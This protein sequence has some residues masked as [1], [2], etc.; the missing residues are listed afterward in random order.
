MGERRI[1]ADVVVPH[2]KILDFGLSRVMT[3]HA[4][5]LGGTRRW[6]APELILRKRCLSLPAA[7]VY[8]VGC[9]IYFIAT[10]V[11]PFANL[12]QDEIVAVA[13][14]QSVEPLFWP[15]TEN[16]FQRKCKVRC[17]ACCAFEPNDRPSMSSLSIEMQEAF[18]TAVHGDPFG[19]IGLISVDRGMGFLRPTSNSSTQLLAYF[20]AFDPEMWFIYT[21]DAWKAFSPDS[22]SVSDILEEEDFVEFE[23]F[24]ACC[25]N[26]S[27]N[28]GIVD[29]S[30][31][32]QLS[33]IAVDGTVG[34]LSVEIALS[35]C[36]TLDQC[37]LVCL[38]LNPV[39]LEQGEV[40]TLATD[41]QKH[42][43]GLI[44]SL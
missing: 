40:E 7:D 22:L 23:S 36:G 4:R 2:V 13:A 3:R 26:T 41:V 24:M 20:D 17:Q 9:L 14:N 18:G 21:T 27:L 28:S 12:N 39:A 8:S 35:R 37:C 42:Q 6:M 16:A 34:W 30:K 32:K 44:M 5:P 33:F 31:F 15:P 19:K 43:S 29:V 38:I 10:G 11:K 1:V 25:V